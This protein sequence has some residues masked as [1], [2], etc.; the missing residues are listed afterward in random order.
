VTKSGQ[1]DRS[2][3]RIPS[4]FQIRFRKVTEEEAQIFTSFAMRP[5]P[6]S[7]ARG[8][9]EGLIS[10]LPFQDSGRVLIEK[11]FHFILNMD[12]RLE[13]LEEILN[14]RVHQD[15]IGLKPYEWV[16]G[17]IGSHEVLFRWESDPELESGDRVLIDLLLPDLP[18]LR[19]VA[20]GRVIN[21]S[22]EQASLIELESIHADDR[23]YL[24]RFILARQ[25]EM[26]RDRAA[27]KK[28]DS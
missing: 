16:S 11:A 5:S 23:E 24:H 7:A 1:N 6:V 2:S 10:S 19:V 8:E 4:E 28:Q 9:I 20:C 18:E 21:Y 15:E 12:Q 22:E 26:L 13:R 17:E 27:A 3:F 14:Q 25:R